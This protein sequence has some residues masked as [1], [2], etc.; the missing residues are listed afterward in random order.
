MA[1]VM[2]MAIAM[3]ILM[4]M[5]MVIAMAMTMVMAM[6]MAMA[7]VIAMAM[8]MVIAMAMV[9]PGRHNAASMA[10]GL[11]KCSRVRSEGC[12]IANTCI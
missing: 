7:M 11:R 9:R 2:A 6:A 10:S 12:V 3:V 5:A 4:A 1:M 8:P